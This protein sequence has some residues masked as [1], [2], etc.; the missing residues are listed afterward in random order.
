MRTQPKSQ[1]ELDMFSHWA[2][3]VLTA[4]A[5]LTAGYAII[6]A[7]AQLDE[8][9]TLLSRS[10][11]GNYR[12]TL[13]AMLLSAGVSCAKVCNMTASTVTADGVRFRVSCG[14][15]TTGDACTTSQDYLLTLEPSPI[16]SR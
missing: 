2:L 12:D 5:L 15:A 8:T 16:P 10:L 1:T 11:P 6:H 9:R 14:I 3:A 13:K 7:A 4:T